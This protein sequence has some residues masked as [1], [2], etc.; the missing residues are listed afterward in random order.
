LYAVNTLGAVC[1]A[2]LTGFLLLHHLGLRLTLWLAAGLNFLVALA[3]V[4][5]AYKPEAQAKETPR[6]PSLALQACGIPARRIVLIG[7]GLTGLASMGLEVVWARVLGILTSNS[8][9]GFALLLSV[10]LLGLAAGSLIQ[11]WWSRRPGDN[12]ARLALCQVVLA[13]AVLAG[14]PWLQSA[15]EGLVK[16]SQSGALALFPG[17]LVLTAGAVF[18]PAL[19]MGLALP[20]LVA[21]TSP[22]GQRCAWVGQVYAANALGCV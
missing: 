4:C 15:P 7:A 11:S 13:G 8:A 16:R 19:F 22:D 6:S 5:M 21:G 20:L 10:V 14:L 1:G 3:G 18:V 17:E 9:Y 12:W 2:G